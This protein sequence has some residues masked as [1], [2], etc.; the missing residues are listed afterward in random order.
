MEGNPM[1][2]IATKRLVLLKLVTLAALAGCQAR[3]A[4]TGAAGHVDVDEYQAQVDAYNRQTEQADKL[5]AQQEAELERSIKHGERVD[6]QADK[7][8]EQNDRI[9]K[10][11][12][13]QEEQAKRWDAILDA[14]EKRAG[15]KP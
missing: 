7:I 1:F 11:I 5:L 12:T 3:P 8:E 6:L 2:R 9:D 13:K 10:L 14:Q 4:E 15:I